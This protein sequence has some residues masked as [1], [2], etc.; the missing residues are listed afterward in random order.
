MDTKIMWTLISPSSDPNLANKD[1]LDM[2]HYDEL[3]KYVY[4]VILSSSD[5]NLINKDSLDSYLLDESNGD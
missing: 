5:S 1:L 4:D 2:S 3:N